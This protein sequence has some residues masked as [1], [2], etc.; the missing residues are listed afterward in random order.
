MRG[1][2]ILYGENCVARVLKVTDGKD[3]DE[4]IKKNGGGRSSSWQTKRCRTVISSW[5][6]CGSST[7]WRTVSRRIACTEAAVDILRGMKPVEADIYIRKLAEETGISEGAI[8][9]EYSGNNIMEKGYGRPGRTFEN[10]E[11]EGRESDDVPLLEKDLI[12]LMLLDSAFIRLSG[13]CGGG[14]FTK[15]APA[16]TY[17]GA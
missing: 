6:I 9:F 7:T 1:L 13:G 2:D 5:V 14:S 11:S 10:T 15:A 16:G 8:R 12:K 17:T 4:F 3:P